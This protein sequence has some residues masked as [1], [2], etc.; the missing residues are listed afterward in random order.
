MTDVNLWIEQLESEVNF[1]IVGLTFLEDVGFSTN[2]G[3]I[4]LPSS[5]NFEAVAE[6]R[7]FT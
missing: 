5:F 1:C 4:A 2:A 3:I 6:D 7:L